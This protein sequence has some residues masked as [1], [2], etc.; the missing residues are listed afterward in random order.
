MLCRLDLQGIASMSRKK[1]RLLMCKMLFLDGCT[2]V[3]VND[4]V[5]ETQT[6]ST[7]NKVP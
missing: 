1:V 2:C 5:F 4:K 3:S 7:S 6:Q